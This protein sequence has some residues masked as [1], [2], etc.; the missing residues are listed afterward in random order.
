MLLN[1]YVNEQKMNRITVIKVYVITAHK[2]LNVSISWLP[3]MLFI[4]ELSLSI[5]CLQTMWYFLV[6]EVPSAN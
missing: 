3:S 2:P 6:S 5:T 4:P 1:K